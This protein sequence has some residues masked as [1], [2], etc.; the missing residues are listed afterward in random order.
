[1]LKKNFREFLIKIH[2]TFFSIHYKKVLALLQPSI[3]GLQKKGFGKKGDGT[4]VLPVELIENSDKFILLSFGISNDTSFEK[5]F[6]ENFP[7]I[8]IYAF[9][10]TI[11]SLPDKNLNIHFY[12]IG[13]A[14]KS[15]K[16]NNFLSFNQIFKNLNL[17]SSKKYIL[18]M[19]IEG[20]EWGFLAK[21]DMN[22]FDI[23]IITVE[24]H[25]LPLISIKE[26][27]LLPYMFFR[28]YK[29]LEKLLS[30]FYVYHLH[31][32]NYHYLTFKKFRFPSYIELTLINKKIFF[33][34]ISNEVKQFNRATISDKEDFQFPF[35]L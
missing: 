21:I 28:K 19:D 14:G 33:D 11:N 3:L 23:P 5:Q 8:D 6:Q 30:F 34:H 18:K 22:K 9:D 15:N 4:Y 12:K 27:L 17:S 29:I 25:F 1:M 7:L 24:L 20:W 31:A 10:P 32:N 35:T 16:S 26:T 13:L 2:K